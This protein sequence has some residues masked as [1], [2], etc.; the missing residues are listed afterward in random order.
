MSDVYEID[1][2]DSVK[3]I[4][5]NVFSMCE[6]LSVLGIGMKNIPA[7][8]FRDLENLWILSLKEGVETIG[9]EAF[10]NC[11][12]DHGWFPSTLKEIGEG[13]FRDCSKLKYMDLSCVEK[14]GDMAFEN[15][16]LQ[17]I[18]IPNSVK[19]I[20][21]LAFKGD[22]RDI[23]VEIPDSVKEI[24]ENAF[25]GIEELIYDGPA[26]SENMWGAWILN[27]LHRPRT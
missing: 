21:K 8:A 23:C 14:I 15:C 16:G 19:E 17:S 20:G 24:G 7:H 6:E 13:A 3:E 4:G 11:G 22:Y 25:W 27:D 5:K 1:I 9:E 2:P 10:A 26:C 18:D 12:I